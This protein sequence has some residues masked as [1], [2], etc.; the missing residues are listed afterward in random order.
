[1][2]TA[3]SA[4]SL[5]KRGWRHKLLDS[6]VMVIIKCIMYDLTLEDFVSI[7]TLYCNIEK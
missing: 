1:M 6:I 5:Y 7:Y 2:S 3:M 4:A